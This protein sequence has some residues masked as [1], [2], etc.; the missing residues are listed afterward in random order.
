MT[1][2]VNSSLTA[3]SLPIQIVLEANRNSNQMF[4]YYNLAEAALVQVYEL[5]RALVG[6]RV[7]DI[8]GFA[9]RGGKDEKRQMFER[10]IK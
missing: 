3:T 7:L 1:Y 6:D 8:R 5:D 2:V 10:K 4:E 9:G